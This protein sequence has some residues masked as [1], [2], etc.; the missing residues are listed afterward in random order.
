MT[1]V[2]AQARKELTEI[3]RDRRAL[4]LALVV[5]VL[6]L[7]I[8]ASGI[9]LSVNDLPIV[10]Q[11]L[12]HSAASERFVDAFR[13][14]LT[15]HVVAWPVDRVPELAFVTN[16]A[17]AAVVIPEHFGRDMARGLATPV[18]ILVDGSDANTARLVA[19][20]AQQV[21]RG[22]NQQ[23]GIARGPEPVQAAIRLWYNPGRSSKKFYGPG[24]FVLVLSIFPSLLAALAMAR[25][26][27]HKTI[28]Q[29][30]VSSVS[31][32][33]FLLGKIL[34]FMIV[35]CCE[36][37]LLFGL[38]A[39]YFG[40]GI[41]GDPTPFLTGT[42][43][44]LFCVVTFGTL[45]G[46]AI[47]EQASAMQAV[48][49]FGYLLVFLLGGLIFPIENIP[50]PLRWVSNIVWGRYYIE[51]VRDAMLRGGGWPAT[52]S[53]VATIGAIASGFYMLAWAR[54]RRMQVS[55]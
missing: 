45:I 15:F 30:Y 4:A 54:M 7:M 27:A 3:V 55:V 26:S 33:E 1:R 43:L 23:A 17:R 46:A 31:A 49:L 34:A 25:E 19:G 11:D 22:Y 32:H 35:G 8:M 38:L 29:V 36:C 13:A 37:V 10:I 48:A 9:S 47:P 14:S 24:I 28:L 42:V 53:Q 51:I 5:P 40:V 50:V 44:Y 6:Q 20:Y 41:V 2:L 21:T 12:D 16:T 39:T 52:W 18:Q